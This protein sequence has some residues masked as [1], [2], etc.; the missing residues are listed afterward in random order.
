MSIERVG[1]R[2]A[3]LAIVPGPGLVGLAVPRI[4]D[5]GAVLDAVTD[6]HGRREAPG[7]LGDHQAV[8]AAALGVSLAGGAGY[9]AP[10]LRDYGRDAIAFGEV[11]LDD[12]VTRWYP[13]DRP[14]GVVRIQEA[15]QHVIGWLL[16]VWL[17]DQRAAAVAAEGF[18]PPTTQGPSVAG[19][20]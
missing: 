10:R 19:T 13:H 3:K 15:G 17:E 16:E 9:T 8:A 1:E 7:A 12:L 11:V 6:V 18:A 20:Q 5:L 2:G 4:L 14:A